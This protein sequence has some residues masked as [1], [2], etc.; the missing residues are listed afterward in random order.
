MDRLTSLR[1]T[2]RVLLIVPLVVVGWLASVAAAD[3]QT[4]DASLD[5]AFAPGSPDPPVLNLPF[6]QALD[7]RNTGDVPL[8]TMVV[9]DTLPVEMAVSHVTT[10]SY[11]GL[12]DFAA[13]EGARVSYEKN[14][15]PGVFTLWGS[16]PNTTTNTTLTAPPPGLGAGEYLTRV[17][18]EYGQAA[19][20]MQ[21]LTRP[22]VAGRVINPD[23]AGGPVAPGDTIQNCA[24]LTA[25]AITARNACESFALIAGPSIAVQAADS[26]PRGTPVGATAVLSGGDPTGSVTFQVFAAGDAMCMTALFEG[27]VAVD[28]VGSYA[29]PAFPAAAAGAYKWVARYGGDSL[30]APAST[31]CNDPAGAFAVVAPPEAVAAFGAS[32]IDVGASTPLTFTISNPTGNT[33]ALTGVSL[34][35]TLPDGLVVASPNGAGGTCGGTITAP[36]GSRDISLTGGTVAVGGSCVF[37][38]DVR[39]EEPGLAT[40]TGVVSS[41]NGGTGNTATASLTVRE[42]THTTLACHETV[43]IGDDATCTVTVRAGLAPAGTVAFATDAPGTFS[44]D[45]CT[46]EPLSATDAGCEVRYRPTGDVPAAGR[47][48]RLSADYAPA[49][50]EVWST[51]ATDATVNVRARPAPP[52]PAPP[53]NPMG[54]RTGRE[55]ALACSPADLVLLSAAQAGRRVRFRGVADPAAARQRVTIRTVNGGRA[56]VRATVVQDGSFQASGP[57][58][59]RRAINKTRYYAQIGDR[60]SPALKLT[61]RMTARL[62]TSAGTV[63]ISGR[64]SPPLG[65]PVRRVVV[66]RLTGCASGYEAVARVRPDARGRFRINLPAVAGP[67]LYRAQTS[68]PTKGGG[69]RLRTFALVLGAD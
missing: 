16:S 11:S 48:D 67:A 42:V 52:P 68:V 57:L 22:V 58:P 64:V 38:V 32:A 8:A 6:S 1:R 30:H 65:K 10:G 47:Q 56:V 69:G 25:S 2:A 17:R 28:G 45:E 9:I 7:V 39:G 53:V 18:W 44:A 4:P 49:D 34:D 14:T 60:R 37:S 36:A 63:T 59:G 3:A 29:G 35:G 54:P 5:I 46:L 27:E 21:P 26:T 13:G 19:A 24:T 50:A 55:L 41:A 12:T 61:R 43:T 40:T 33:V 31:G 23:N 62:T 51:S 66:R 15:A 20:G